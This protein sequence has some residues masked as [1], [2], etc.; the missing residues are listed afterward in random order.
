MARPAATNVSFSDNLPIGVSFGSA[1]ATQGS[2]IGSTTVNCSLGTISAGG[3]A[4]I[5]IVVTPTAQGVLANT[6]NASASE[7]DF[8]TSNNSATITTIIQP[9]AT[10]TCNAGRNL[11]VST[12]LAGLDQPTT[13]AFIG[14]NDFLILEKATGKVQRV[15]NGVLQS[16]A[17]DLA[18]QLGFRT[19]PAGDRCASRFCGQRLRLSVLDRKHDRQRTQQTLTP[20]LSSAI[21][22]IVTYGTAPP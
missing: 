4:V 8:D 14:P 11:T 21:G 20:R 12:V 17:L 7:T 13:L 9:V 15:L 22:S 18:G 10:V 3:N 1:T 6:A 2:C 16:P 19:R 5:T